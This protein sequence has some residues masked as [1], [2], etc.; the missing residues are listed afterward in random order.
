MSEAIR[1]PEC[2]GDLDKEHDLYSCHTCERAWPHSYV[3]NGM[4]EEPMTKP[5]P[6]EAEPRYTGDNPVLRHFA[7]LRPQLWDAPDFEK[8]AFLL[9]HGMAGGLTKWDD[10]TDALAE[11]IPEQREFWLRVQATWNAQFLA[12]VTWMF[13][14][15]EATQ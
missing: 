4:L 1:C 11:L 7:I 14:N 8:A 15:S 9:H 13:E 10:V 12:A 2:G 6:S 5:K 3:D